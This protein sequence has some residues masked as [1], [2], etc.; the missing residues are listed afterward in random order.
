[1]DLK[2]DGYQSN[3]YVML[4]YLGWGGVKKSPTSFSPATSTNEGISLQSF[5]T[6]SFNTFATLV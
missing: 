4:T 6:F 5:L 1:M 3:L 2:V